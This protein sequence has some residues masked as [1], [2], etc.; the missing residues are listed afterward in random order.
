MS[1]IKIT[2]PGGAF[3][4]FHPDLQNVCS[5]PRG[6][7]YQLDEP[8]GDYYRILV[9]LYVHSNFAAI[10]YD[11][12]YSP[13]MI[14]FNGPDINN[15]G[16]SLLLDGAYEC[17]KMISEYCKVQTTA[18][19]MRIYEHPSNICDALVKDG[20]KAESGVKVFPDPP[21]IAWV[22]YSEIRPFMS[23]RL[24]NRNTYI[25]VLAFEER[26]VIAHDPLDINGK[27]KRIPI[28]DFL[29]AYKGSSIWLL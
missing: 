3:A 27:A 21:F 11:R 25:V 4:K 6:G 29:L 1:K 5:L 16:Q 8:E 9:P 19:D 12:E 20:I 13:S 7:A 24:R 18:E 15:I 22:K 10:T 23:S 26:A 17:I 28:N 2:A 14:P